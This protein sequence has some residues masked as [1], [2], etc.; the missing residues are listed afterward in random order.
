[1]RFLHTGD[2]HL[3]RTLRGRSR[4]DE[5]EAALG[6]VV[7]IARDEK[8]DAVLVA[9]DIYDQRALSAEADRLLFG[10][11]LEL[12]AQ[13]IRVVAIPGNH[14]SSPRLGAVAPLLEHIGCSAVARVRRPDTGG[15]VRVP[16]RDGKQEAL[17]AC[18]PFVSPRRFSD[19]AS[20]FTD[21]ATGYNE[22]DDGMGS[23]LA[24][25]EKGFEA[26]C[27]N[28]VLGHLFV[29]GAQPAG[30][31]RQVT[32]GADYAVSPMR[33]P[34]RASYVALGHIHRPQKVPGAP[35]EARYAGSL[36][37]LDFGELGQAKSVVLVDAVPGKPPKT[38]AIPI[39]AGR[40]LREVD[41]TVD[42]LARLAKEV[43]D[44]YLRVN[45]S[46]DTPTPGLAD[47]V[48]DALPNALDIRLVLPEQDDDAEQK[49]LRGLDPREQFVAYYK[50]EHAADPAGELLDAF[51]R[52]H[53]EVAS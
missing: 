36:I 16:A 44:A 3:G 12:H 37:Q 10:T 49:T 20:E 18:I 42:D 30:S 22:Y 50:A 4:L 53:E 48:R 1:M 13:R 41:A 51:D 31:E 15:L 38:K 14:D 8:V 35:G 34:A 25:Y 32:I 5:L 45:L 28:V 40:A 33:L 9:G 6:Q 21:I 52:V 47:R 26:D 11:L 29:S 23:L 39:T 24:A 46:V 27:V 2:W 7:D 17:I 19:A 43:G